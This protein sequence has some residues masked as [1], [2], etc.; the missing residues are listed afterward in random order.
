MPF[1]LRFCDFSEC[2][3]LEVTNEWNVFYDTNDDVDRLL[4]QCMRSLA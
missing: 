1:M 4:V 3:G 2:C